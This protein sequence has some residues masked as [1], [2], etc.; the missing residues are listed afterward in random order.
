MA[1]L[2][3]PTRAARLSLCDRACLAF[4]RLTNALVLTADRSWASLAVGV[5]ITVVR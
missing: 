3:K 4:G 5:R 1:R 2:R